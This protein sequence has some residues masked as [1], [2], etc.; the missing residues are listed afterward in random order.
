MEEQIN[1]FPLPR[2]PRD[3]SQSLNLIEAAAFLGV[4]CRTLA[5]WRDLGFVRGFYLPGKRVPRPTWR[6][7][8]EELLYLIDEGG[9]R[10]PRRSIDPRTTPTLPVCMIA[11]LATVSEQ[12]VQF[13]KLRGHL[14][15]YT[16]DSVRQWLLRRERRRL[17]AQER[18]KLI[19]K[20]EK[21]L[22]VLRA[23][24]SRLRRIL[25]S[26]RCAEC[27]KKPVLKRKI[28]RNI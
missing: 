11:K 24:T 14:N 23:D 28:A 1:V 13:A 22:S 18:K 3:N 25:R 15:D 17:R 12:A 10:K 20:Y 8:R 4:N 2:P 26:E 21:K 16:F 19:D 27:R 5:K 6:V 9:W 7:R